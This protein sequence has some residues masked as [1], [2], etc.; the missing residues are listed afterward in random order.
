M[1]S[2]QEYD[3]QS[4]KP[5]IKPVMMFAKVEAGIEIENN[6]FNAP[7]LLHSSYKKQY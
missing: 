2:E 3:I 7:P 6:I 1:D 5:T 4:E